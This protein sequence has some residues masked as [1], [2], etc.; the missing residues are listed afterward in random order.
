MSNPPSNLISGVL[1]NGPPLTPVKQIVSPRLLFIAYFYVTIPYISMISGYITS[2]RKRN[3]NKNNQ[4]I[5]TEPG[6]ALMMGN[7]TSWQYE[8][9]P[10]S[11]SLWLRALIALSGGILLGIAHIYAQLF[12]L[13]WVALFPLLVAIHQTNLKQSYFLGF[14]FGIGLYT[15]G[16]FWIVDFLYL[17]KTY[18][19][20]TNYSASALFWIYCAQMPACLAAT[21]QWLSRQ[22]LLPSYIIFP[23][24]TVFYFACFPVLFSAQL[25]ETQ[26]QFT[27]AL[28]AIEFTGVYGLDFLMALFP[29]GLFNLYTKNHSSKQ[30]I[31]TI[32]ALL[33][34]F[35]FGVYAK[36]H[37]EQAMQNWQTLPIGIVQP[38]EPPS[39]NTNKIMPGYSR[40]YPPEM[41]MTE[42]LIQNKAKLIV[43]PEA[44]YKGYLN[45]DYIKQAYLHNVKALDTNLI[46]Q[47]MEDLPNTK[48]KQQY[49]TAIMINHQ[50]KQQPLYRKQKRVAFGE[51]VPIISDLPLLKSWT[52]SFFGE[53]LNEIAPGKDSIV[54]TSNTLKFIPLICYETMFPKYVANAVPHDT[55]GAFLIGLSS[56][57]WFGNSAQP[58]QHI[59]S[60]SLRAVENRLPLVHALNNGPSNIVLPSGRNL[61]TSEYHQAGG[62]VVDVPYSP[63]NNRTFFSQHPWLVLNCVFCI[64]IIAAVSTLQSQVKHR[65][66]QIGMTSNNG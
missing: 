18:E 48:N 3:N 41:D 63:K 19:G 13:S 50:G 29:I 37:W 61:F 51:Y 47:D 55:S 66:K 60:A 6:S 14:C 42:R 5:K 25:G 15:V 2:A 1:P 44:K 59:H 33:T 35:S 26:S 12:L 28:Q 65:G 31:F 40:T 39:I 57:G 45:S 52:E 58:Y 11:L 27:I 53:F 8:T 10:N 32:A 56:N 16:A 20:I 9:A 46:F 23:S 38:N 49:N 36:H 54:F 22:A 64:L 62:Y 4:S 24:V 21:Y 34:W 30:T 43:W 17:F 7:S